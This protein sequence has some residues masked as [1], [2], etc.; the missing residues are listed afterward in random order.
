MNGKL[1]NIFREKV[2]GA[3]IDKVFDTGSELLIKIKT[4]MDPYYFINKNTKEV[5]GAQY[6]KDLPTIEKAYTN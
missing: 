1:L 5:R 4:N 3:T 6:P 2:P